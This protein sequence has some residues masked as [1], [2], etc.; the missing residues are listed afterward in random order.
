MAR[1]KLKLGPFLGL[2]T[3][4]D[5]RSIPSS[6]A[7]DML[8]VR[9]EDGSLR[10]RYGYRK[11]T[12]PVSN[13]QGPVWMFDYHQGFALTTPYAEV[14]E[15]LSVEKSNSVTRLFT[16]NPTTGTKAEV[17][18]G[19]TVVLLDGSAWW[20][21]TW[22][23][24]V[25]LGNP[26]NTSAPLYK[27]KIGDATS[28]TAVSPATAP[29]ALSYQITYGGASNPYSKINYAGLNMTTGVAYVGLA[30]ASGSV[31]GGDYVSIAHSTN[32]GINNNT[33]TS[34][35]IDFSASTAG[36]RDYS[37]NDCFVVQMTGV[38]NSPFAVNSASVQF[39]VTFNDGTTAV[40]NSVVIGNTGQTFNYYN[41]A[42]RLQFDNKTRA[43][44]ATVKKLKVSYTITGRS[45]T[46]VSQN[47]LTL[48]THIGGV[49]I[50]P[51]PDPF[52]MVYAASYYSTTTGYE[53]GLSPFLAIPTATAM[54]YNPVPTFT[55]F[56]G[57]GTF[58]SITVPSTGN[59]TVDKYRFYA[60]T[61]N[62]GIWTHYR[63]AEQSTRTYVHKLTWPEVITKS[64]YQPSQF[65]FSDITCACVHK[66]AMVYGYRGL[67]QESSNNGDTRRVNIR[68]SRVGV[69]E[70][71]HNGNEDP[72]DLNAGA[73]FVLAD[74]ADEPQ[75]MHSAGD[76]L[77]ILGKRGT[78]AMIGQFPTQMIPP[79]RL[80]GSK[81]IANQKSSCR[82]HDAA[83]N[84]G[85]AYLD[86]WGEL[87]LVVVDQSFNE[88]GGYRI[89]ELSRDIRGT[90]KSFL[91]DGQ[92]LSDFSTARLV[93]NDADDS[94]WLI[95]G[96]R[97]IVLRRPSLVN[98]E[99]Q[100]ELYSYTL[101]S[102]ATISYVA[103][104][105][106]WRARWLRSTGQMD[107][108]EFN[109]T[110]NLPITG[111][112]RDGGS[113]MPTPY[114][115]SKTF[116]VPNSRIDHV[117]VHRDTY[118]NTPTLQMVCSRQTTSKTLSSGKRGIRFDAY[119]QGWEHKL[120]V[121]MSETDDP[122]RLVEVDVLG[123]ISRRALA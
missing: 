34:F 43:T 60:S 68:F 81:G 67:S 33:P 47:L 17:K 27:H 71:L 93:A 4:L 99:R 75:A 109:T 9:V 58:I 119:Q 5:S 52:N 42:F 120:K 113:V 20:S 100:W 78:H 83:G 8:N 97:A 101:A 55:N 86:R 26:N 110:T 24:S 25:Y 90:I 121:S 19:T 49:Q 61:Q 118:T 16:T 37:Y 38:A 54:G 92:S 65:N 70:A 31:N 89:E 103:F 106:K 45:F 123:P 114:W 44:W 62:Q 122:I 15:F 21:V 115:T 117:Q 77:I 41:A 98:G 11:L 105:S 88:Q 57:I 39:Q 74:D 108:V 10:P 84:A 30:Q 95:M 111:S 59:G 50:V 29:T 116:T 40:P 53:S 82:W 2:Q 102:S 28:M 64:S 73:D 23:D 14:E 46:T 85:V 51:N 6:A 48:T 18:D 22:Q 79:K 66:G 12:D 1:K 96:T 56:Q 36:N 107:E 35:E 104:S 72:G 112:S 32:G 87:W 13:F 69:P 7:S 91:M 80:P 94:L 76:A 3:S 63:V